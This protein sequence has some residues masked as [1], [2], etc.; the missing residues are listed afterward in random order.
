MPRDNHSDDEEYLGSDALF[1]E[2]DGFYQAEKVPTFATHRLQ[3]GN[4]LRLR[5]VGYNPLWGHLLWNAG[6]TIADYLEDERETSIRDKNVLELGAGAGLPSLVCA[7]NAARKVVVTDYPDVDLIENL[8]YNIAACPHLPAEKNITAEGYLWGASPE[9]I[10]SRLDEPAVGFDLLILADILFN[11]S[12]HA[13]LV[14]TLKATLR[15]D[16]AARALVFFT[17]YRPWLFDKDM[18]FFKLAED[19]SFTTRKIFEKVMDD[20]LF[21]DDPG[22]GSW[23]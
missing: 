1:Q 10:L 4:E 21:K 20:V 7:M 15:R 5:L 22:N 14:S 3:S 2:P 18:A 16:T 13:K 12:E 11:H 23:I 19:N 9:V 6:R 17:P 8:E